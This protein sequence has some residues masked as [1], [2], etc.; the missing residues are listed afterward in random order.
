MNV[1]MFSK[2]VNLEQEISF[3][4]FKW[5]ETFHENTR[6]IVQGYLESY[7]GWVK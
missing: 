3:L 4:F 6:R 5:V 7:M 1:K 2:E